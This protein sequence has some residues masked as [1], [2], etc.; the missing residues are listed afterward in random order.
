MRVAP[1]FGDQ[2][3]VPATARSFMRSSARREWSRAPRCTTQNSSDIRAQLRFTRTTRRSPPI[4]RELRN[5]SRCIARH[6]RHERPASAGEQQQRSQ[7]H[8]PGH[9]TVFEF[10]QGVKRE[11]R[12]YASC[13]AGLRAHPPMCRCAH[14][15]TQTWAVLGRSR[16]RNA[17]Q[18]AKL[19]GS[20]STNQTNATRSRR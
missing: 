11:L 9:D 5:L 4:Q 7:A 13:A 12:R 17:P 16:S 10:Q 15:H 2:S 1:L 8:R 14:A 18:I 3:H 20:G 19:L 6:R